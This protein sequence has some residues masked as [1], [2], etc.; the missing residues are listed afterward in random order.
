MLYQQT[1]RRLGTSNGNG[2]NKTLPSALHHFT[3]RPQ[4]R[5]QQQQQEWQYQY[6]IN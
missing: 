1:H 6:T 3:I 2:I 5:Q 4:Q